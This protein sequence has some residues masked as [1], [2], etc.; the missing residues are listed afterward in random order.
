[1]QQLRSISSFLTCL[2]RLTTHIYGTV[3]L[4][5]LGPR[6]RLQLIKV[7]EGYFTGE[8]LYHRF[9]H[10]TADEIAELR[11]TVQQRQ[12]EREARRKQQEENVRKKEERCQSRDWCDLP[13]SCLCVRRKAR[14]APSGAEGEAAPAAEGAEGEDGKG[15]EAA[16][17][18]ADL[19]ADLEDADQVTGDTLDEDV[20]WYRDETGGLE[21]TERDLTAMAKSHKV[22]VK[23][24]DGEAT[25]TATAPAQEAEKKDEDQDRR[26]PQGKGKKNL[27]QEI[28]WFRSIS[29]FNQD[30]SFFAPFALNLVR[31]LQKL[32]NE[33]VSIELKNGSI[34]QGTITGVDI[35]MN[36]HL[37]SVKLIARN[38]EALRLDNMSVRG[39]NIRYVILPDSLNLDTLLV[40]DLPK[41]SKAKEG[42]R[43]WRVVA[44]GVG[45]AVG[46]V[47]VGAAVVAA[48]AA[49]AIAVAWS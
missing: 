33:T 23:P 47:V 17:D 18:L 25:A 43:P 38:K 31:F 44:A 41:K 28:R 45:A 24:T 4:V 14:K 12:K 15:G 3:S 35:S 2:S 6:I 39:N 36:A 8:V 21:P 9:V 22:E 10:K 40:E 34:I 11:R 30:L 32:N 48:V 19:D 42:P 27:W 46:A 13:R 37:K 49:V 16:E 5:E 29:P 26:K 20:Q 1:M 7:E